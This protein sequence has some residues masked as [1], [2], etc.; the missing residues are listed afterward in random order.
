MN[1]AR[2]LDDTPDWLECHIKLIDALRDFLRADEAIG[3]D[4]LREGSITRESFEAA[5]LTNIP[6]QAL[7]MEL[8]AHG[9]DPSLNGLLRGKR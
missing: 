4:L 5:M 1:I 3:M 8:E 7:L 9:T 2:T 6:L